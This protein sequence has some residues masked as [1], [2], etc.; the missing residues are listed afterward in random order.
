[1]KYKSNYSGS[2]ISQNN[3][4]SRDINRGIREAQRGMPSLE[5]TSKWRSEYNKSSLS[6]IMRFYDYK[7]IK[8]KFRKKGKDATEEQIRE[9]WWR[10]SRKESKK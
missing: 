8:N 5:L 1:M 10:E 9:A 2:G 4:L 3:S 7:K 6:Y